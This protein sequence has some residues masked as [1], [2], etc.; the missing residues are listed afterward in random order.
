MYL[1]HEAM[2]WPEIRRGGYLLPAIAMLTMTLLLALAR[3]QARW[4]VPKWGLPVL[5]GA[6]LV[7]NI[8]ALPSHRA[9]V[10]A[11]AFKVDHGSTPA[12]LDALRHLRDPNYHV[13][14]EVADNRVYRFFHDGFFS[15]YPGMYHR[16]KASKT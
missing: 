13:P 16:E 14:P 10:T 3:I 5:L 15:R 11:G 1:R 8:S 2:I 9:L 12:V 7:G 4:T 6:V